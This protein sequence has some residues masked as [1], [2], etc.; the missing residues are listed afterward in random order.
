[1]LCH[2]VA[3]EFEGDTTTRTARRRACERCRDTFEY[4]CS[5]RWCTVSSIARKG[6]PSS[7]RKKFPRRKR[8]GQILQMTAIICVA[9][10][11]VAAA[12][13]TARRSA[14]ASRKCAA[15][16]SRRKRRGQPCFAATQGAAPGTSVSASSSAQPQ[17]FAGAVVPALS[18]FPFTPFCRRL[19][20]QQQKPA[21]K[22]TLLEEIAL[23]GDKARTICVSSAANEGAHALPCCVAKGG[24]F[25]SDTPAVALPLGFRR[26]SCHRKA[27]T[28]ARSTA[29]LRMSRA[30]GCLRT[31]TSAE[32]GASCTPTTERRAA[33]RPRCVISA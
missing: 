4:L 10:P 14:D 12:P 20:G 16:H 23:L 25:Q 2:V 15:V 33:C 17:A 22:E 26:P 18:R 9:T 21:T 8:E 29:R 27:S 11:A 5:L 31:E 32:S 30:P 28:G 1:M 7:P 6:L 19:L 13:R 24:T 3:G